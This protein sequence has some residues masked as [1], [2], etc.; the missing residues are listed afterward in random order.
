M[1]GSVEY[2]DRRMSVSVIAVWLNMIVC[3]GVGGI[4]IFKA[5]NKY[6]MLTTN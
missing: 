3:N 6:W 2:G 4:S 5:G 1:M